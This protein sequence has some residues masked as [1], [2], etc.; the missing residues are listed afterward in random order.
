MSRVSRGL[1]ADV[2]AVAAIPVVIDALN[3]ATLTG[4]TV[5]TSATPTVDEAETNVGVLGGKVNLIIAALIDAG[6]IIAN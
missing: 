2:A 6:I 4:S 1:P 5:T 3:G